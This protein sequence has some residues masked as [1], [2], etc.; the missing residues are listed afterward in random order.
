MT[1]PDEQIAPTLLL[2]CP[3]DDPLGLLRDSVGGGRVPKFWRHD[4]GPWFETHA[5]AM[6]WW[7]ANRDTMEQPHQRALVLSVRGEV[8]EIGMGRA[9]DVLAGIDTPGATGIRFARSPESKKQP[10]AW[11][12]CTDQGMAAYDAIG[13]RGSWGH[14]TVTYREVPAL[15]A[16]PIGLDL[17]CLP[18][19]ALATILAARAP[20]YRLAYIDAYGREEACRALGVPREGS[21]GS[22][23]HGSEA[24][25]LVAA[26]ESAP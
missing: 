10:S 11:A 24:E 4:G 1:M 14:Y 16:S 13:G 17:E 6:G 21:V 3:P 2:V 26:L 25:A 18:V 19:W 7:L 8:D 5:E 15:R 20:T 12:L 22:W 23:G 9:R